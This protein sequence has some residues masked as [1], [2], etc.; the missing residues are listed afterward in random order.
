MKTT[1]LGT[2]TD[3]PLTRGPQG[4]GGARP[5]NASAAAERPGITLY[6]TYSEVRGRRG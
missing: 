5:P 1:V 4:H 6:T 3:A 2:G